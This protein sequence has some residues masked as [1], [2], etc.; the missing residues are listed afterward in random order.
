MLL[1]G[2][3]HMVLE[4]PI[5]SDREKANDLEHGF[6]PA[7]PGLIKPNRVANVEVVPHRIVPSACVQVRVSERFNKKTAAR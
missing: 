4:R 7:I 3:F 5:F 2:A 1:V 6:D